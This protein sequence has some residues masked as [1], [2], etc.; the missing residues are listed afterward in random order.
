M[1]ILYG[2]LILDVHDCV[3]VTFV[4]FFASL[5]TCS[6]NFQCFCVVALVHECGEILLVFVVSTAVRRC[7]F[8]ER[9]LKF[10]RNDI[11]VSFK[12]H[13]ILFERHS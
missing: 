4:R 9:T 2:Q 5:Y 7:I 13:H 12:R 11:A 10:P 8:L 3:S 6:V 1:R